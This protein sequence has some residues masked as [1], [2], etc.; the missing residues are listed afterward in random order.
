MKAL[1]KIT[2]SAVISVT[3]TNQVGETEHRFF[4][5]MNVAALPIMI[6]AEAREQL[7]RQKGRVFTEGAVPFFMS[8]LVKAVGSNAPQSKIEHCLC[9][10][11]MMVWLVESIFNNLTAEEFIKSHLVFSFL[12]GGAVKFDRVRERPAHP[13]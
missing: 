7:A 2:E 4:V 13:N 6:A 10:L 9:D 11:A 8:E 3:A 1:S 5:Q 12:P